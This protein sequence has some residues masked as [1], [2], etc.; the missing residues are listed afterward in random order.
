MIFLDVEG[1]LV[2]ASPFIEIT[3]ATMGRSGMLSDGI[4]LPSAVRLTVPITSVAK[5]D[6][7]DE[8]SLTHSWH[9]PE[10]RILKRQPLWLEKALGR[11]QEKLPGIWEDITSN[12]NIPLNPI[13]VQ[14]GEAVTFNATVPSQFLVLVF[15]KGLEKASLGRSVGIDELCE[16]L[17]EHNRFFNAAVIMHQRISQPEIISKCNGNALTS[18]W[19]KC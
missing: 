19:N 7:P 18:T 6:V 10:I 12:Q 17:R 9:Q 4:T 3:K 16:L 13:A 15:D 14:N 11:Q 5:K 8:K 1:H 2:A